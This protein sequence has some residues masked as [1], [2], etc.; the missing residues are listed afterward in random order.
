M[1]V[2][3]QLH[4]SHYNACKKLWHQGSKV[5]S[6]HLPW[7]PFWREP[8]SSGG[9]GHTCQRL[10]YRDEP[11]G[12]VWLCLLVGEG[13]PGGLGMFLRERWGC[14]WA[15]SGRTRRQK[16]QKNEGM[17]LQKQDACGVWL[18]DSWGEQ[19]ARKCE[20]PALGYSSWHVFSSTAWTTPSHPKVSRRVF[21]RFPPRGQGSLH[22]TAKPPIMSFWQGAW[23]HDWAL[24]FG[25][26]EIKPDHRNEDLRFG[27]P[28]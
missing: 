27:G 18:S 17:V 11:P 20:M 23:L 1:D 2:T 14:S 8:G 9:Q 12:K 28:L 26:M 21:P 25:A 13:G 19:R 4:F 22:I 10:W 6:P 15:Q 16:V 3:F 24:P 5:F 7:A